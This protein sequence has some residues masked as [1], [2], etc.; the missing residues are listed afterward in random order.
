MTQTEG[1]LSGRIYEEEAEVVSTLVVLGFDNEG[2]ARQ[3]IQQVDRLKK[4]QLLELEDAATV[5]RNS[6]GKVKVNQ[7]HSLVGAGAFGG[8]FWGM[9]IGLLFWMPWLGLAIG[10]VTGALSGKFADIG[11]DD[12]FIKKVSS[13]I[14]PGN[15]ALFLMVRNVTTDRVLD[16]IRGTPGVTVIE[17]SLSKD[18][19][20][21]LR[22]AFGTPSRE[23]VLQQV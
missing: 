15:S 21:K 16:E 14:Q 7:A 19:E 5:V 6:D 8:A 18:A 11:I 9:L 22:E 10:A 17:T 23:E 4:S 2:G 12:E 3:M 13:T 20:E 1:G